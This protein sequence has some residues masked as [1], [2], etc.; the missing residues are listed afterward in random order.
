MFK[1]VFLAY[2]IFFSS[3]CF[4]ISGGLNSEPS[5]L[6]SDNQLIASHTVAL[7]NTQN[8]NFHSR[9]TG[10]LIK[11]NV[12][13]T[14]AHCIPDQ[15]EDLWVVTSVYEFSIAQRHPVIRVIKHDLY[16]SFHLPREGMPNY[17]LALVEFS[18]EL[19]ATYRPTSWVTSWQNQQ[20][21]FSLPVAGYGETKAQKGD[22][23]ELRIGK[24]IVFDYD[25]QKHYFRADQLSG[26]GICKGDSGGPVFLK[27]DQN[28]YI[29]GVV[30]GIENKT[31]NGGIPNQQCEGISYFNSTLFYQNW[32]ET[33]LK[34]FNGTTEIR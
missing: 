14:A 34:L 4:A 28:F 2:I 27:I 15:V 5:H 11:S 33:S 17:D 20:Q 7:L 6:G 3:S 31:A 1:A 13:L 32:I 29:V 12:I 25:V 10:T 22:A 19:P 8:A 24:I 16:K 23:G 26:E 9:C 18:G 30:S 21:R